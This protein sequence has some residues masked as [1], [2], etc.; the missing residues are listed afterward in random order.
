MLDYDQVLAGCVI[1]RFRRLQFIGIGL[2]LIYRNAGN[3]NIIFT[4]PQI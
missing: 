1:L 4:N 3:F 2:V